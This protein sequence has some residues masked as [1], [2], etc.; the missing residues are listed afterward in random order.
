MGYTVPPP[1]PDF[2]LEIS[3]N[4]NVQQ[5]ETFWDL[6]SRDPIGEVCSNEP[7]FRALGRDS[8][9]R[10]YRNVHADAQTIGNVPVV[11][12]RTGIGRK[13]KLYAKTSRKVR[14]E[15]LHDLRQA[16]GTIAHTFDGERAVERMLEFLAS[17]RRQALQ[18]ALA[19]AAALEAD[20]VE[21]IEQES[22]YTL[23]NEIYRAT[24][25]QTGR[26]LLLNALINNGSYTHRTNDPL[27]RARITL[28]NRGVLTSTRRR[29][30]VYQ[31]A[32]RFHEA[33]S[34]LANRA[35][36]EPQRVPE[37]QED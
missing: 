34:L 3:E 2:T 31:L 9:R 18:D 5:V 10:I 6:P 33:R 15:I 35:P 17:C 24:S 20:D 36:L 25:D 8:A 13:A 19:L 22:P 37:D 21:G 14:L 27:R 11:S 30:R 7:R 1:L 32:P 28:Q 4:I 26:E 29:S 16:D 23:I 12:V